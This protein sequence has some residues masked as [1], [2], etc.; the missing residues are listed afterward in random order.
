MR[1]LIIYG[2]GGFAREVYWH[3]SVDVV[4]RRVRMFI[5]DD[6]SISSLYGLPVLARASFEE[7]DDDELFVAVGNPG[8]RRKIVG[9]FDG[10]K[11]FTV[12]MHRFVVLYDS[13]VGIGSILCPGTIVTTGVVIGEHVHVNL[14]CT[15][16]HGAKIGNFTTLSPGVHVSGNVSIG[17]G[18]FVG[19]GVVIF[20]G[21]T[22]GSNVR[23]G[24][25]A[26]VMKNVV[27]GTTVVGVPARPVG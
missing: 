10:K 4:S 25:G 17:E 16:G 13:S 1:D 3:S 24:A 26:V 15:I 6:P 2:A 22:I 8:A 18:V 7:H 9:S 12:L 5:D 14:N 27:S 23:I 21:V 11:K 20:E 19:S